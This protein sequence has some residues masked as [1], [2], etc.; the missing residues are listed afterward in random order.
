MAKYSVLNG[1]L[2]VDGVPV[3][4]VP[5]P[6]KRGT[7]VP[8]YLVMHYTADSNPSSTI[9]WFKDKEAQASAHL[10]IDREGKITQF[11]L[12]TEVLWHAGVSKWK[13][14]N[15]MNSHAIGI[16]LTNLGRSAAAKPGFIKARH[17]NETVDAYW[18][19]YTDAQI[20]VAVDVAKCLELTYNLKDV[21]GHDDIS[22]LRK[23]DPGPAFPWGRFKFLVTSADLNLREGAA[24]TFKAITVLPK[25]TQVK[26]SGL[27]NGDWVGVAV[28]SN[29]IIGWVNKQYLV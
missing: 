14:L 15:G 27:T 24:T 17:K 21:I 7:M 25:G 13:G 22:P 8:S 6:N 5:T 26:L 2:L 18:Q 19:E 20:N 16:E 10:L 4:W 12:F 11:G 3:S 1:K 29:G 23:S 9:G 28:I